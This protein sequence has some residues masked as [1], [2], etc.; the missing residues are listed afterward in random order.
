MD[1]RADWR[2]EPSFRC[3]AQRTW[4]QSSPLAYLGC[5]VLIIVLL[6][7]QA[8]LAQASQPKAPDYSV[9]P[10]WFAGV[11]SAYKPGQVRPA[12]LTNSKTLSEMIRDGKIQLSLSQLAN[13]V[14][15]NNL[16]LA[17]DRYFNYS[18]QADLQRA[19]SGQAARGV[20]PVGAIIPDALFS[21]A[22]GAGVGGGGGAFGGLGGV[23]SIS[24][25]TRAFSVSPRGSFDPNFTFDFSWDRTAS[26]LNTVVVAGSPVVTTNSAFFSFGWVQSFTTGTSFSLDIANQ[27]QSSTQ[28][29]LIYDPDVITRMGVAVV[30]QLTNGFGLAFNRRFQNVAR[31]NVEF[32]REWFLRQVNTILAQ[33]E[34]SY[35]DLVSAQEQIKATQQALQVAQQLYEDNKRQAEIGTLAPLDV[36][37]AQAQVASTQRD[38]IVAQTNFQQQALT[39]KTF[40]GRQITDALADAEIVAADPLPDPQESDIP[41]LDEAISLA[42][43]NRPEVP[44]AQASVLNNEVAVKATQKF[45]KPTFNVF[46]FFATAGLYGDQ[47]ISPASGI[48]ILV[49]GGAGQELN[50]LIHVKYPEYAIGFSLTIPIKN[51]SAQADNARASMQERQSQ[52]SKQRTQNQI[53]VEVRSA[54][55]KLTQ[56]KAEVTAAS[57]AVEFSRQSLD[58]E[59]KKR[60]AG[61]ST[62]YNVI[63]AQRNLLDAQL[64]EVQARATYAKAL[65]EM[66]RSTGVLLEKS[67]VDAER[68]ILGRV[69]Q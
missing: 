64:A 25:A 38:L 9:G 17:A 52:L 63:L 7:A 44:Q 16:N 24:G 60:A 50:Q 13:A 68:A 55:I 1:V 56:A 46:G 51:R 32:V 67:H 53:G 48:P 37:S 6:A 26:P 45:L 29:S 23:G 12:D 10:K 35:W 65:V 14:V 36:V 47:M 31:N 21:A 42:A 33:A 8:S 34:T 27:R 62:P 2:I 40:F 43:K 22:I 18:A 41:P 4:P 15:E 20:Q 5:L 66:E 54:S 11:F 28:Q 61:L 49:K 59:Q 19:R 39:L 69:T 57:S 58:A 30:Q 3:R